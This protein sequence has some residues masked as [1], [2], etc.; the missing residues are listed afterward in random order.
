MIEGALKGFALLALASITINIV[1][2]LARH[3]GALILL[4]AML[5]VAASLMR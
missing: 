1:K 2:W 3:L 4:I 5:G